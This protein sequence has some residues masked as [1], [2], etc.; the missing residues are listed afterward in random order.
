MKSR[1]AKGVGGKKIR[2]KERREQVKIKGKKRRK[3][4]QRK[5]WKRAILTQGL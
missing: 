1:C 2:V 3:K 4:P 5:K